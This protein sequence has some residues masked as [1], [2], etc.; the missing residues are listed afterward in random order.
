MEELYA[1]M[2]LWFIGFHSADRYNSLLD[3]K[4]L[5]E[6]ENALYFELEACSS[7]LSDTMGRFKRYLDYECPELDWDLFGKNLFSGLKV[8]Y[9]ANIFGIEEFGNRC[10][11]LWHMLPNCI[12]GA[13]PFHTLI[14]A[15]DPMSWGDEGQARDLYE[16]AFAFYTNKDHTV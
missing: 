14:Y 3:E 16:R 11:R 15:D 6:P 1:E 8:T 10:C 2:L 9:D 4:F 5:S 7:N 12:D 13:E